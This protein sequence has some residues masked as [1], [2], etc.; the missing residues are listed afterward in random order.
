MTPK[1]LSEVVGASTT[2]INSI[3][4]AGSDNIGAVVSGV[5]QAL[6][7]QGPG[8]NKLLT[9]ASAVVDSPEQTIADLDSITTNLAQVTTTLA[10]LN[11]T[12]KEVFVDTSDSALREAILTTEGAANTFEGVIPV[13]DMAAGLEKELGP[14]IQQLLDAVSV[15]I[16]KATPRAPYYASLLNVA[17]RLLNGLVNLANNHQFALHY[18]PPTY[19]LRAPDGVAQC[20][21]MNAAMPGSCANVKGTPYAVDV[22]LLQYVLA[23][24]ASK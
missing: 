17:P 6:H 22:A 3:N 20:N 11:P 12:L 15:V 19:R 5:D 1:S 9:T 23:Q 10:E 24:A 8:A 14:Q 2:F 13:T 4:P 18:R 21:I 7:D 16:R